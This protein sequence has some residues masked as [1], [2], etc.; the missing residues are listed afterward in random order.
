MGTG[1]F[2]HSGL[3][4]VELEALAAHADEKRITVPL[5]GGVKALVSG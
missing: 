2:L 1:K 5:P 3:L 4:A